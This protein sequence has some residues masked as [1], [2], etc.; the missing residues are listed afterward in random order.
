LKTHVSWR[1]YFALANDKILAYH[2]EK[3]SLS[4]DPMR[5]LAN[6]KA[7]QVV[8]TVA[9]TQSYVAAAIELNVTPAAIGQQVR[10]FELWL[11]RDVFKRLD[12]GKQRL[13]LTADAQAAMVDFGIGLDTIARGL[14][15]LRQPRA[16]SIIT[17][18][19]SQ[20]FVAKWLMPRLVRFTSAFPDINVRLDVSDKLADVALGDVD[21]A[22][23]CGAGNWLNVNAERL[24]AEE[25]FPV[26]SPAFFARAQPLAQPLDLLRHVLI[27]DLTAHTAPAVHGGIP[28][29]SSWLQLAGITPNKI[30][31]TTLHSLEI[32]AAATA[33]DAAINSQ[34]IALA[35]RILVEDDLQAG[36]LV[37]LC[38]QVQTQI[39]WAYYTVTEMHTA[40][41]AARDAFLV[42]IKA[43][44]QA[45]GLDLVHA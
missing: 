35:R 41:N 43:E 13:V 36:K 34:G 12:S 10:Q 15:Q 2:I 1:A 17:I 30:A 4:N 22:I 18:S 37:R 24:V 9:R 40:P 20:A 5:K 44:V 26:C 38:P 32:N 3:L 8:E 31:A 16:G 27:H 14:Q 45:L 42:W 28:N 21:I 33:I 7:I 23:R 19:A 25:V 39:T 6:L 29:W 11:G